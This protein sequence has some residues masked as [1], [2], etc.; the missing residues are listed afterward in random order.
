MQ[1]AGAFLKSGHGTL[2][3]WPVVQTQ[4]PLTVFF[5]SWVDFFQERCSEHSALCLIKLG[6]WEVGENSWLASEQGAPK[7]MWNFPP[8]SFCLDG[9]PTQESNLGMG[10]DQAERGCLGLL[11][12]YQSVNCCID[13]TVYRG[14]SC[15]VN[16]QTSET[17]SAT[18]SKPS[19]KMFT[20]MWLSHTKPGADMDIQVQRGKILNWLG[21]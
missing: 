9:G 10:I 3:I 18:T 8:C 19:A 21:N 5:L 7:R 11:K 15:T 12:N 17:E 16:L 14:G 1:T 2:L 20:W 13:C 6:L 4:S